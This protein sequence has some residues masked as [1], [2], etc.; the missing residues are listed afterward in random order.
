VP[1]VRWLR[2]TPCL[3]C[4]RGRRWARKIV[5]LLHLGV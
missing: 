2:M 5:R 3:Y 1:V 4:C